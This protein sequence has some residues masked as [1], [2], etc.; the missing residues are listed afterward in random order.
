MQKYYFYMQEESAQLIVSQQQRDD[1][2]MVFVW[3]ESV[4]EDLKTPEQWQQQVHTD[5]RLWVN[6]YHIEDISNIDHPSNFDTTQEYDLLIFRK[7]V[8]PDDGFMLKKDRFTSEKILMFNPSEF[9]TTPISFCISPQALITIRDERN[10]AANQF[11]ER[12]R[13]LIH[14]H[15]QP[16]NKNIRVPNSPLDLTL[17]LLNVVIDRY[18]DIRLPLTQRVTFWQ[19]EL[20][21]SS[22]R[23]TRWQD[24]FQENMA[25]QQ[26]EYLCEEQIDV[27]QELR[28]DIMENQSQLGGEFA[29]ER[30]DITLVRVHDLLSHVERVQKHV[31]RL[32]SMIK[33]AIDLH[34]SAI[35]NQTNENMR[36]L[37]IITAIFS[38]LT[39]L[40]GIYGMNFEAIP[41]LR[42]PYGFWFMMVVMIVTTLILMYIFRRKR[43]MGS[44]QS[45]ISDLLAQ[46]QS[47]DLKKIK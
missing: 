42:N 31:T 45:K 33:T 41:G 15:P 16:Q 29:I 28:D 7:L 12:I 40:T 35:S 37:A 1:L 6:E 38:P 43:L 3:I 5:T 27:L 39:L 4:L 2:Q 17:K 9:L 24:L 8:T 20:L 23:F 30:Q 22:A 46:G 47:L 25:L 19:N 10:L 26:I 18:L 14:H 44:S 36:I 32:E 11:V 21:Q 34:F 13:M